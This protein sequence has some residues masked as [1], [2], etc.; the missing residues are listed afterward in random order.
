M[1][2][3]FIV[4]AGG[5]FDAEKHF[6]DTVKNRRSIEEVEKYLPAEQVSNLK[7]IYHN[8]TFIAWG[9]IPGVQNERTWDSMKPGDLVLITN[10]GRIKYIGEVG[11]KARS[12]E[13]AKYFWH[14]NTQGETWELVYF[15]VNDQ[16]V[17]L[18]ISAI[19][20]LIGYKENFTP[21][22][23]LRVLPEKVEA[24][25]KSY[26]DLFGV[27]QT[28]ERGEEVHSK[29]PVNE[30]AIEIAEKEILHSP[31]EHDEMQWR[32]IRLGQLARCDVWIPANDKPKQFEGNIFREH[33]LEEFHQSLDVPLS[34]RNIDVVWKFGPYSIKSAFEI[35]N[36]T[37]VYSGILRLSDLRTE[38]QNSVF[39]LVIVADEERRRKVFDELR[40]PT[41]SGPCLRL[42]EVVRFLSY[43]TIREF[44]T[45]ANSRNSV[46]VEEL[47]NLA[48]AVPV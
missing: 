32:L 39:P 10:R 31:T 25:Y 2:N 37:S 22:G 42:N 19:N 33:V 46:E 5:N 11:A 1:R 36:S 38:A 40:R 3:I 43:S 48:E 28:L 15:I 47:I 26:G 9:S 7:N 8:S 16:S 35:E 21:Q 29:L 45:A 4:V 20:P 27:L 18:P 23:F 12:K 44:D 17:D 41:F 14:E 34:I 30:V 13:L 24:F 6:E